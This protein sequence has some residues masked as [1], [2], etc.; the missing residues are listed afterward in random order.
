MR[1]RVDLY[2]SADRIYVDSATSGKEIPFTQNPFRILSAKRRESYFCLTCPRGEHR[3][4]HFFSINSIDA[5]REDS[6]SSFALRVSNC[7]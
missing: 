7:Q 5:M 4:V 1:S 6:S 3:S 2:Y